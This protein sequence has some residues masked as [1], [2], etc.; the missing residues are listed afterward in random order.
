[1]RAASVSALALACVSGVSSSTRIRMWRA[2]YCGDHGGRGL[3]GVADLDQL[4]QLEAAGAADRR[5]DLAGAS[6]SRI[7]VGER[8]GNLVDAAP[9]QVAAFQRVGAVGVARQRR[10]RSPSRRLS[11][12]AL[13]PSIFFCA[14]AIC[15]GVAPSGSG[16]RMWAR[17]NCAARALA[18]AASAA[19]TSASLT[20]TRLCAKR[21]RRR[22]ISS[23]SRI[24]LRN[25]AIGRAVAG[26]LLAQLLGADPVLL[27]DGGDGLVDFLVG[28]AHAGVL[29]RVRPAA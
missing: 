1:M 3:R 22:W 21:W 8:T 11:I 4:D 12:R 20:V 24:E 17:W 27:G 19:S 13:T 10:R 16:T 6:S 14:V 18:W 7:S 25:S 29:A 15:S 5:G 2:W 23:S 9:A 28:D 26:D